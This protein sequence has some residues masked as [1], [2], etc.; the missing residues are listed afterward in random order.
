MQR[1]KR[2]TS[3]KKPSK[4]SRPGSSSTSA[5]AIKFVV[6]RW[7]DTGVNGPSPC[8]TCGFDNEAVRKPVYVVYDDERYA[9]GT[10][11]T[12]NG[13]VIRVDGKHVRVLDYKYQ[14]PDG[15]PMEGEDRGGLMLNSSRHQEAL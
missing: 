11:R 8:K 15:K 5:K 14:D 7:Q 10:A 2:K 1:K 3:S 12:W 4:T 9:D 6:V 13:L